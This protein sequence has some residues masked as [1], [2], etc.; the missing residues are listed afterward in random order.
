MIPRGGTCQGC[1]KYV[2]WGDIVKAGYVRKK[3][4]LVAAVEEDDND[5]RNE[6]EEDIIETSPV[7]RS[8]SPRAKSPARRTGKGKAKEL[9]VDSESGEEILIPSDL[10]GSDDGV[11]VKPKRKVLPKTIT[12]APKPVKKPRPKTIDSTSPFA[13]RKI[14]AIYDMPFQRRRS[15]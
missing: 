1:N 5:I 13:F 4:G 15:V 12:T 8:R 6:E 2:L 3:G 10:S 11:R 14:I 7:R 9:V